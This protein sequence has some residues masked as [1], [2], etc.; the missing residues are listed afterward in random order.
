MKILQSSENYLETIFILHQ[1]Q[2][3]VR[4]VDIATELNFS[5]ASVSVAMKQLR[6]NKYIT[7]DEN[8]YISLLPKG[9]EIAEKMY[10]RH[11]ILSQLLVKI[12]VDEEVA[13]EDACKIEHVISSETFYAIKSFLAKM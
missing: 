9:L 1:R 11:V 7:M 5:K 2:G 4:S 6:E 3:S 8:S 13:S 10:E 12:G